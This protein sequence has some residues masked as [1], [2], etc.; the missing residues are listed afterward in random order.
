MLSFKIIVVPPTIPPHYT[1]P[2]NTPYGAPPIIPP[3]VTPPMFT[4][5]I[6]HLIWGGQFVMIIFLKIL[7]YFEI[8]YIF[9][10]MKFY[11][12]GYH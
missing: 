6:V 2:I 9:E 11:R 3:Y 7:G 5:P 10:I 4:L 8:D 12:G 1:P